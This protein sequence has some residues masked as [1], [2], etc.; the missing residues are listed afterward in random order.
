MQSN[1]TY[2]LH[3]IASFVCKKIFWR[4]IL[5]LSLIWVTM[6]VHAFSASDSGYNATTVLIS[7][8]EDCKLP[9]SMI[10]RIRQMTP[11][12]MMDLKEEFQQTATDENGLAVVIT[13]VLRFIDDH[14]VGY[15]KEAPLNNT[16]QSQFK[17]VKIYIPVEWMCIPPN[18]EHPQHTTNSIAY[19]E[20]MQNENHCMGW[21]QKDDNVVFNF[22]E[23]K[24]KKKKTTL[25]NIVAK[26]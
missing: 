2:V 14:I 19:L 12:Q 20:G 3:S 8:L 25:K 10:T 16:T 1:F 23:S 6:P 7:S 26:Q 21:M 22:K 11:E 24:H 5:T 18:A 9:Q 13:V 17:N 4:I 15:V